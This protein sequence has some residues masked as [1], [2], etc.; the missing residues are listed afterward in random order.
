MT[1][2]K[3]AK[4]A[5]EAARRGGEDRGEERRGEVLLA[6]QGL[7]PRARREFILMYG[8]PEAQFRLSGV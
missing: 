7:S 4:K 8:N 6:D 2:G 1:V 3:A 5:Q